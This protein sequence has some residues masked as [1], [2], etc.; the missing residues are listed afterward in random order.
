MVLELHK[1]DISLSFP[2]GFLLRDG[3]IATPISSVSQ[4]RKSKTV[5]AGLPVVTADLNSVLLWLL[6]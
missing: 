5:V 1:F 6:P 3:R 4:K 2:S